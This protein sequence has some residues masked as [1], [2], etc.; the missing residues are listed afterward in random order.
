[1]S[2]LERINKIEDKIKN[3]ENNI[4]DLNKIYNFK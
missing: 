4:K 3:M 2:E 1:M